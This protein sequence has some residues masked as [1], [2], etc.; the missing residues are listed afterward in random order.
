MIE[1]VYLYNV[2]EQLRQYVKDNKCY[3]IPYSNRKCEVIWE[4]IKGL[5]YNK[6]LSDPLCESIDPMCF[7]QDGKWFISII[8]NESSVMVKQ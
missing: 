6:M 8:R 5:D 3:F 4:A 1:G 2:P 7:E